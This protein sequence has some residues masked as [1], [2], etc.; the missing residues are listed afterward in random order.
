ME[1]LHQLEL[2]ILLLAVV[3]ALTT[4]ARR[5]L[6][7]YPILLVI[8]GLVL[9]MVPGMPTVTLNPDLVFLVFLPP[10]L[11]SAAYFTSLRDF[12]HNIRPIS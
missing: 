12:R 6:I 1:N 9:A 2:V 8:G 3:L 5:I 10:I 7:P 4:I 11:W